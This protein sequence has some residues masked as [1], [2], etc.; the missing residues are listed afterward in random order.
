MIKFLQKISAVL[1]KNAKV[2]DENILK[3]IT[4]VPELA[5]FQT[6]IIWLAEH[7]RASYC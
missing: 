2:F 4:S 6:K 5:C 3:I 7:K 1:A